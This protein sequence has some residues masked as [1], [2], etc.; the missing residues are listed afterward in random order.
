MASNRLTRRQLIKSTGA[1]A[2]GAA[3]IGTGGCASQAVPSRPVARPQG[4]PRNVVLMISDGMSMGVPSLAEPFGVLARGRGTAWHELLRDPSASHGLLATDSDDS[5]VTDS[6]AAVSALSSGVR[7]PNGQLNVRRDGAETQPLARWLATHSGCRL[8]VVTTDEVCGATPAGFA[9]ISADRNVYQSIAPQ[10]QG[11]A[12]VVMGGGRPHFTPAHRADQSDLIGRYRR[13]GYRVLETARDLRAARAGGPV[14][15]LFADGKLPYTLDT[16]SAASDV[17]T[18]AEMSRYAL[19][20]LDDSPFFLMIEGARIDHAAHA[21]DGAALLWDQ[22]AFDDA[23]RVVLEYAGQRGD[24]LVVVTSDHGN[25]NPGLNGMGERY[26]GTDACFE[27]LS[28][29]TASFEKLERELTHAVSRGP[30]LV[31]GL[32]D[33]RLGVELGPN[34]I[35]DVVA[36]MDESIADPHDTLI[37]QRKWSSILGQALANHTG[38]MFTSR[39]HTQDHVL[40]TSV[41]PGSEYFAGLRHHT[42]ANALIKRL[43]ARDGA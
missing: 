26:G 18:L 25:S 20:S 9:A 37:N 6:A 7:V 40:C 21:N 14:L 28:Q 38:L 8:G 34:Q 4:K 16:R 27:K 10:F 2:G 13:A 5:L 3:L 22:L 12:D 15:G 39:Q 35:A 42:D 23:V 11:R 41:G 32:I 36:V 30:D 31:G 33:Q 43:L 19:E 17:P 24:T 1:L 29:S